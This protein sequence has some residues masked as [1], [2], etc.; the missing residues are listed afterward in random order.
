MNDIYICVYSKVGEEPK[1]LLVPIAYGHKINQHCVIV[2]YI[3]MVCSQPSA[4]TNGY[5]TS[6]KSRHGIHEAVGYICHKG[7]SLEGSPVITCN[8]TH[9]SALP[10]CTL[11][12]KDDG[13]IKYHFSSVHPQQ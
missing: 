13:K 11:N 12:I 9:W 6:T 4:I 7:Y 2:I 5:I 10:S 3:V 1:G 8:G